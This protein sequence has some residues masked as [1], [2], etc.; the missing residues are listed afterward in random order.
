MSSAATVEVDNCLAWLGLQHFDDCG[1]IDLVLAK[2]DRVLFTMSWEIEDAVIVVA[3]LRPFL[4]V[5][6]ELVRCQSIAVQVLRD[7][8]GIEHLLDRFDVA[9]KRRSTSQSPSRQ[10]IPMDGFTVPEVPLMDWRMPD[11]NNPAHVEI[12]LRLYPYL[13]NLSLSVWVLSVAWCPERSGSE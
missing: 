4:E 10:K 3:L 13:K 5:V 9:W 11:G 1:Q 6:Q 2:V 7:G 8:Q 12:A